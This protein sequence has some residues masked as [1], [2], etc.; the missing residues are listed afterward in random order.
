MPEHIFL[1][2]VT[3]IAAG[4]CSYSNHKVNEKVRGFGPLLLFVPILIASLSIYLSYDTTKHVDKV[5]SSFTSK[6]AR[7]I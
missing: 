6:I 2:V 7:I 5:V 1:L 4:A 3:A